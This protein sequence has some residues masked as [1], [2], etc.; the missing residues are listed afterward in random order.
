MI[1]AFYPSMAIGWILG[2]SSA[3]AVLAFGVH[4]IIVSLPI[5]VALYADVTAFQL[6]LYFSNRRYNVSPYERDNST[7]LHGI[8]MSILAAPMYAS[9]LVA[10]LL[11]R[12]ARFVVTPKG[13]SASQDGLHTFRRH[14]GW[15]ALLVAATVVA[16]IRGYATTA[17]VIWASINTLICV[18][19]IVQWGRDTRRARRL[20]TV[21]IQTS[22]SANPV[23]ELPRRAAPQLLSSATPPARVDERQAAPDPVARMAVPVGS[24][25]PTLISPRMPQRPPQK[26]SAQTQRRPKKRRQQ[27]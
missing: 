10:T 11:R 27:R 22:E 23:I 18:T 2:A 26:R 20:D 5:W 24:T 7:G 8:V 19:P 9:Q 14:L 12:P 6:W 13:A 15:V 25:T 4:G 21:D 16:V 1:T 17:T 3:A